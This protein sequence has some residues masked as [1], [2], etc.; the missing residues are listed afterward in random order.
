MRIRSSLNYRMVRKTVWMPFNAMSTSMSNSLKDKL[1]TIRII[2]IA[3]MRKMVK[4]VMNM[5]LMIHMIR[6]SKNV[7]RRL[8]K[9]SKS[10]PNR[11][12]CRMMDGRS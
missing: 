11:R 2:S 6:R 5:D 12:S 1:W 4:R 9:L 3:V 7:K 10:W 8:K